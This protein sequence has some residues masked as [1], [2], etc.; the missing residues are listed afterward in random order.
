MFSITEQFSA[1]S[2]ANLESQFAMFASLTSKAFEGAEK[3]INLHLNAVRASLEESNAAAKQLLA[4]KDLNEFFVLSA[5]QAQPNAEKALSYS[6]HLAG[7]ASATQAEFAKTAEEQIAENNRKVV[8][9]VDEVAKNAPAG[10]E[11]VI[12]FVKSAIGNANA[13]YE[14]L[15]KGAKQA[16]ETLEANMNT[17]ANQFAQ[18]TAKTTAKATPGK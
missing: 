9:L 4:A 11:T 16:A 3:I 10:S 12:A 17:T 1:A 15:S 5:A 14:Q 18:A 8:S 6:R 13:G 2:K 7:I